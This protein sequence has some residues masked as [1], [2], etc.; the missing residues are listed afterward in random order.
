MLKRVFTAIM[1][2]TVIGAVKIM[3]IDV[4]YVY[5][6]WIIPSDLSGIHENMHH[7]TFATTSAGN[8]NQTTTITNKR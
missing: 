7:T 8:N 6:Q 3:L 5:A 4:N 1:L 2:I